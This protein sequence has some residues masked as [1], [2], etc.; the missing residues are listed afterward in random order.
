MLGIFSK[1]KEKKQH[2]LEKA[3]Q[4]LK[5]KHVV[6]MKETAETIIDSEAATDTENMNELWKTFVTQSHGLKGE[7]WGIGARTLGDFFYQLECAGKEK[8]I[9]KIEHFYPK[10]MEEWQ[11]VVDAIQRVL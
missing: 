7:A 1:E 9:E 4:T 2:H 6:T 3:F 5:I 10:A 8:N 11:Q